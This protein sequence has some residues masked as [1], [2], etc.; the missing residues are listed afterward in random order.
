MTKVL[1]AIPTMGS[2]HPAIMQNIL[3]QKRPE[4][5]TFNFAYTDRAWIGKARNGLGKKAIEMGMDWLW[6]VDSDTIPPADA[7]DKMLKLA[8]KTGAG[9]ICPPVLDRKG[10]KRL[11]LMDDNFQDITEIWEDME[12]GYGGMS[13]TLIG[14]EVLKS[15]Y[16]KYP[17]PFEWSVTDDGIKTGE[18]L[19]FC[20]RAK[21]EGY[22][23]WGIHDV[24]P[25]HQGDPVYYQYQKAKRKKDCTYA[26]NDNGKEIFF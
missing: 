9:I 20:Y 19:T 23:I 24:L 4:G 8:N 6:F 26:I 16:S 12:I 7:L 14:I 2:I 10:E 1:L 13:C 25:K 21:K 5:V 15:V 22:M 3:S 17:E 11:A 18:D